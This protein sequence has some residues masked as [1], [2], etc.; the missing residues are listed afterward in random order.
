MQNLPPQLTLLAR[1]LMEAINGLKKAIQEH[2]E[3]IRAAEK[4]GRREVPSGEAAHRIIAFDEKTVQDAGKESDRQHSTQNSIKRATWFAAIAASIYALISLAVW[5]QTIKQSTIAGA[6][7]RQ[8]T[9]SF[10]IDER[11]WVELEPV[12]GTLS[13]ARTGKIGADFSYPIYVRNFGKT[14]ARNV[15]LRASRQGSQSSITMGDS[16]EALA[17]TQDKLLLGKVST[18]SGIPINM[19]MPKVLA[20]NTSS[21]IPIVLHGQE[22]QYFP[23]DEWVSYIIG[24]VDYAD[25]FGIPH[26]VK[27]C[28]FVADAQGDVWYCKEGNDEDQNPENPPASPN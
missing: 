6:G 8:S 20:P 4:L 15:Q 18:A 13:S 10:R 9:E 27:F 5:R 1:R 17:W 12:K 14:V 7:L 2:S 3:S 22:P 24:R 28:F 25:E 21:A 19:A 16:A 23:K 26:W 11:A